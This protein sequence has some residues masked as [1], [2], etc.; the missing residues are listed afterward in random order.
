[1]TTMRLSPHLSAAL[2]VTALLLLQSPAWAAGAGNGGGGR[3]QAANGQRL[4]QA[5]ERIGEWIQKV[6]DGIAKHPNAPAA[7]KIAAEKLVAD[8]NAAKA[9]L[10]KAKAAVQ[11]HDRN[12]LQGVFADLKAL[13]ETLHADREALRAAIEAARQEFGKGGHHP[14]AM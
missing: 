2:C 4:E 10:A 11:A 14:Q 8:L 13:R 5:L 12:A 9:T 6:A 1:M 7:V 3:P